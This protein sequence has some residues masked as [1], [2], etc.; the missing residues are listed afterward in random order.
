MVCQ[1]EVEAPVPQRPGELGLSLD[2]RDPS[3]DAVGLEDLLNERP[4]GGVGLEMQDRQR[5]RHGDSII[6]PEEDSL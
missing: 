5:S 1:D 6:L 2:A 4:I 3:D